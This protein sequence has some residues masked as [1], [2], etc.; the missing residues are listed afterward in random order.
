MFLFNDALNTFMFKDHADNQS[1]N[2]LSPIHELLLPIRRKEMFCLKTH[3][4]GK[5]LLR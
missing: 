3:S 2:P 1:G 5:G 4:Y